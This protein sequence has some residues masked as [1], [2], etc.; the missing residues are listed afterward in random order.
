[1]SS[2][3]QHKYYG[4]LV[5]H[6]YVDGEFDRTVIQE[7]TD[8]KMDIVGMCERNPFYSSSF[9]MTIPSDNNM[10]ILTETI[11]NEFVKTTEKN[12][13]IRNI[14]SKKFEDINF[15]IKDVENFLTNITPDSDI[16]LN[17]LQSLTGV[18]QKHKKDLTNL[19]DTE[20][21]KKIYVTQKIKE[22]TI[23]HGIE[24]HLSKNTTVTWYK[25]NIGSRP[26]KVQ[27]WEKVYSKDVKCCDAYFIDDIKRGLNSKNYRM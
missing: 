5:I 21:T 22:Y 17:T 24:T 25:R 16:N 20:C 14:V 27:S 1:M 10:V 23:E 19:I 6:Y 11:D 26:V 4:I 15:L 18:I 9:S 3:Q 8:M 12:K 2:P 13:D 7:I